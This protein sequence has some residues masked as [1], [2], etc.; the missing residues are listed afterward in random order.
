MDLFNPYQI[1]MVPASVDSDISDTAYGAGWDN[2]T[3]NAPSKNAVFD[4][5]ELV[6]ASIAAVRNLTLDSA[7]ADNTYSGESFTGK[8]GEALARWDPCYQKSDGKFWKV[9]ADQ[10]TTMPAVVLATAAIEA[11]ADGVL[12]KR[13]F[14]RGD[15]WAGWTVPGFIYASD[16]GA[17]THTKPTGTGDIVQV[18]GWAYA[19]KVIFFDPQLLMMEI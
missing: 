4:K 13:G 10:A 2:V 9:D 5:I 1:P 18:L 11:E 8:A 6:I 14:A 16:A 12:L 3:D 15:A 17:L 7:L 19:A